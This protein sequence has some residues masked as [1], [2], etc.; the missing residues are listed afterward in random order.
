MDMK[1]EEF[2]AAWIDTLPKD[3]QG[4]VK[5]FPPDQDYKILKTGQRC[6]IVVYDELGDG[7]GFTVRVLPGYSFCE[8]GHNVFGLNENDIAPW[9]KV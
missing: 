9:V 2:F 8:E 4:L 3:I 7:F 1:K 5:R 6:R